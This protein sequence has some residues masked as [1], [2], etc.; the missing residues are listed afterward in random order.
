MRK[1]VEEVEEVKEVEE[2]EVEADAEADDE[3]ELEEEE[4]EE[5]SDDLITHYFHVAK[6]QSH[7]NENWLT[8][9]WLFQD[10]DL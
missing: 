4:E 7:N 9:L 10:S 1:E 2:G 5:E 6:G 3:L 8:V